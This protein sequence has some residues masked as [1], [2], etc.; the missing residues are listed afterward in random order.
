MK[1]RTTYRGFTKAVDLYFDHLMS[2]V[3]P[4]QVKD[5]R[6][7]ILSC[8]PSESQAALGKLPD[9]NPVVLLNTPI[10]SSPLREIWRTAMLTFSKSVH[11]SVV[12]VSA[13]MIAGHEDSY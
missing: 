2:R 11:P 6:L 13:E 3:V 1:L 10:H 7:L 9:E 8:L 4:L 5:K 12:S